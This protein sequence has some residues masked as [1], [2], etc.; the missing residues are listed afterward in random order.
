M[1]PLA[2]A[3]PWL[4][5]L[6]ASCAPAAPSFVGPPTAVR[7]EAPAA[8]AG[9][10]VITGVS[11]VDPENGVASDPHDI[12]I[13]AGRIVAMVPAG[14]LRGAGGVPRLDASG[15]FAMAGLI[16]VHAHVGEG[17]IAPGSDATRARALRQ[18]LRY[19]VTTIFVPGATGA[20]DADFPALRERCR[21]AV[22]SCPGLYGTGS[23]IT[24]PGS[25]PVS[26]I[27]N[28]PPDVPAEVTEARGVTVLRPG[29]DI[30]A[31]IAAKQAAGV[32]AIKIVIED[33]PPPWYPKPRLEDA[34]IRALVEAA[35]ARSLP[36]FA[37]IST[38]EH[39]RIALDAGVDGIMHGPTDR[40]P[41][42]LV[43]RMAEQRMTY[44]ATF[45]LYDGIL[46]WARGQ[47]ESDPYALAGVEPSAIE[48]L[49]AP[50]FLA[51]AAEDEAGALG[52]LANNSDNLR[53]AAAA[54]VPIALG[55]DVSNPFVFPGY[56]AHEELSWMVRAGLT[57]AQ[58]LQAG[59]VGGAAFLRRP[60]QVGRVAPGYEADFVLL[61]RNPLERIENS[62]SIVA[63]FADGERVADVVSA[64]P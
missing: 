2:I 57:P 59:T 53:R 56:S 5:L 60:E 22:A 45:A 24:A 31:L 48:S 43:R 27:F 62:R 49:T 19:G 10:L 55:T 63:V 4:A 26:T 7:V 8:A 21:A 37:H 12:L 23:L 38:S 20:G 17:G 32:D 29:T 30:D 1:R 15:L 39:V 42:E 54:G 36:V 34:Q 11:I 13:E 58:A 64:T 6:G 18:F 14:T 47:R 3:L 16:D 52:Y 46:T 44:V 41:D 25:H 9:S 28:M 33:G 40:L 61:A 50:P 51:A 35:H